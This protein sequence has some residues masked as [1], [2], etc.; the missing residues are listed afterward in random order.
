M[1]ELTIH[2]LSAQDRDIQAN[3]VRTVTFYHYD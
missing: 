3:V 1:P 2:E